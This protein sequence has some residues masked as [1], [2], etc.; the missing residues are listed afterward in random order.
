MKNK[1]TREYHAAQ[2]AVERAQRRVRQANDELTDAHSELKVASMRLEKITRGGMSDAN[3]AIY[4][5]DIDG[6]CSLA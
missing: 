2:R 3:A 1:K 5:G 6:D 4:H